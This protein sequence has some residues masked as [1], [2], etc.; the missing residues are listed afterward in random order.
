MSVLKPYFPIVNAIPPNAP[1]GANFITI[2]KML[3]ILSI[4]FQKVNN[5]LSIFP[6]IVNPA[7][8][9][10]EKNRTCKI[11]PLANASNMLDGTICKKKSI[12]F[13][14]CPLCTYCE[15][16]PPFSFEDLIHLLDVQHS[17]R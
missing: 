3:K 7:P 16:S 9:K 11:S 15:T 1:T 13:I 17:L 2:D 14:S 6:N 12:H 8:N 5:R 4:I 10:M